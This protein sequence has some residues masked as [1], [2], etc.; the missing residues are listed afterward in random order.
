MKHSRLYTLLAAVC[1]FATLPACVPLVAAGVG[2]TGVVTTLDRRSYGIQLQDTEI[3]HR[4]N[5][6][7]STVLE[8]KTQ[9]SATSYNRWVLLTGRAIDEQA[10]A[11]VE[12]LARNVPNVRQ[13][14]NEMAIGYPLPFGV[15]ASDRLMVTQVKARLVNNKDISANNISV[16]CSNGVIYLMGIVTE[17]EANIATEIARTTKGVVRVVRVMEV[18]SP[19]EIAR[20]TATTTQPA[21]PASTEAK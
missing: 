14:Y 15:R 7:F 11:E 19:E 20:L 1:L 2:A 6:S 17:Q 18:V 12:Q 13:V 8:E 21:A 16:I 9:A 3:E 4:F 5:H 10:K